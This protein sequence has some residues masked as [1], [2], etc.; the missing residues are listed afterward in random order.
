MCDA[1]NDKHIKDTEGYSILTSAVAETWGKIRK[2]GGN[3]H[4]KTVTFNT[5]ANQVDYSLDTICTDT[6][7]LA[8]AQLDVNEGNGQYRPISRIPESELQAFRA[9]TSVI[10]MRLK[11]EPC[12]P[13]WT[14]GNESFDGIN[15]W[16][17]HTLNTAA[18]M[19]KKKKQDDYQPFQQRKLELERR[20]AEEA[21]RDDSEPP[22]VA[23]KRRRASQDYYA[24]WRNNVSRYSV[25]GSVLSLY[26]DYGY[27]G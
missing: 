11:Y 26:Y 2:A 6:D 5:V 27:V 8:V 25:R 21:G 24:A 15:G 9:P 18:V 12:A 22:R 19:V 10:A 7:F 17:E 14:T 1:Q 16:E 23:R 13:V 20:I 4:V 3:H